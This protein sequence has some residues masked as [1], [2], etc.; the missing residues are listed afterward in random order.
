[1]QSASHLLVAPNSPE[2]RIETHGEQKAR[3]DNQFAHTIPAI[4]RKV[5]NPL[6]K[7]HGLFP[8]YSAGTVFQREY[9]AECP[10]L[11]LYP[12]QLR[13]SA[14]RVDLIVTNE[15]LSRN[16]RGFLAETPSSQG[17][18]APTPG[19]RMH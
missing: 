9:S 15:G 1:M 13:N 3:Q 17:K 4:R 5:E 16:N 7:V 11:P 12:N 8:P 14:G 6:E 19:T 2:C 18:T 10:G